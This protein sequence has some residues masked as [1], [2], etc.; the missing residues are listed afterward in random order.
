MI[1]FIEISLKY[2]V[3]KV[4]KFMLIE[5]LPQTDDEFVDHDYVSKMN[6]YG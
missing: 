6:I 2:Y 4:T 5:T 1:K 3:I